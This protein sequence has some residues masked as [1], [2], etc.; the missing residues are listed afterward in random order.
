MHRLDCLA[1]DGEIGHAHARR[2]GLHQPR[3]HSLEP[4]DAGHRRHPG[5]QGP[6]HQTGH[7][8][9]A[10]RDDDGGGDGR[11]RSGVGGLP[12]HDRDLRRVGVHRNYRMPG[13][14]DVRGVGEVASR[15]AEKTAGAHR[16]CPHQSWGHRD[17]SAR[18]GR[19][20]RAG[21]LLEGQGAREGQEAAVSASQGQPAPSPAPEDRGH[22][23]HRRSG[24]IQLGRDDRRDDRL[25]AAAPRQRPARRRRGD[26]SPVSGHAAA[27]AAEALLSRRVPTGGLRA[28]RRAS[29]RRR[30]L[31]HQASTPDTGASSGDPH[32][33][34]LVQRS[35][36]AA[37]EALAEQ[38]QAMGQRRRQLGRPAHR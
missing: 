37:A 5:P 11:D 21:P 14:A 23:H 9:A 2:T 34:V 35:D 32:S 6:D 29:C 10:A 38:P 19:R 22:S 17:Q 8:C 20:T 26:S 24:I 28:A 27:Q 31:G 7:G 15:R 4:P 13:P 18:G 30:P 25:R 16:G 12:D 33:L 3:G 36:V 1:R